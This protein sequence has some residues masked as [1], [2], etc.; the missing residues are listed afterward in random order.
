MTRLFLWK[1]SLFV[2]EYQILYSTNSSLYAQEHE[3]GEE[4]TSVNPI[5]TNVNDKSPKFKCYRFF[6]PSRGNG[7]IK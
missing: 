5:E 7:K 3:T 1:M 2:G 4:I 6:W